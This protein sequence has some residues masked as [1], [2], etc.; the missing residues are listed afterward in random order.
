[1]LSSGFQTSGTLFAVS[2]L[3]VC[4]LALEPSLMSKS[5]HKNKKEDSAETTLRDGTIHHLHSYRSLALP[6]PALL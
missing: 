3:A 2:I 4:F 5:C 1:M 6:L